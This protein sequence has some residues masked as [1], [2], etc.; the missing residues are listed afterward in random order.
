MAS[1]SGSLRR[2]VITRIL[3]AAPM[4][5]ILLTLVFLL[6]R[7]APGNPIVA[8]LGGHLSPQ[9]LAARERAAG[10]DMPLFVQYWEYL[11]QVF[12]GNLGTTLTDHRP[13][14]QVIAQN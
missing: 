8:A 5:L 11:R 14:T 3:L 1:T 7:V 4:V 6:M 12:T 2:Y 9:Q 10:Y 13:L